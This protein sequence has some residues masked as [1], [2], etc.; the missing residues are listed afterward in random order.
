MILFNIFHANLI[1]H[2]PVKL[3]SH[4]QGFL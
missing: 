4:T 3:D 1:L 2:M